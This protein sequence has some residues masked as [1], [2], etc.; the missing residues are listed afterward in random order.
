MAFVDEVGATKSVVARL[1]EE[2]AVFDFSV[3]D[4]LLH[5]GQGTERWIWG[6]RGLLF[7]GIR[8]LVS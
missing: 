7:Y 4:L 5:M 2:V 3:F 1:A 6:G 8:C